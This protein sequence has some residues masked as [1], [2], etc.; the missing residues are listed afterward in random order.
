MSTKTKRALRKKQYL[1]NKDASKMYMKEY[2]E[3]NRNAIEKVKNSIM[4]RIKMLIN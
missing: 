4:N 2:R 1:D 3:T